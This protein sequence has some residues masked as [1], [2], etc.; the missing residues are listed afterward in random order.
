MEWEYK[1]DTYAFDFVNHDPYYE[2]IQRW[3]NVHG[4]EGWELV[5]T[6]FRKNGIVV[7]FKRKV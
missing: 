3:L 1:I 7:I 4:K 2:P 5:N 6:E